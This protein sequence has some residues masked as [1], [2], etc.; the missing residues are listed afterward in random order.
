MSRVP[1]QF[2]VGETNVGPSMSGMVTSLR[3]K[4]RCGTRDARTS[5]LGAAVSL[6]HPA[7][8]LFQG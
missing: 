1:S 4:I 6:D 2:E 3:I 5:N 7:A 8:F